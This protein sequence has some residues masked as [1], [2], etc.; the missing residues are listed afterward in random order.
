M[1]HSPSLICGGLFSNWNGIAGDESFYNLS[2]GGAPA[3][4]SSPGAAYEGNYM[5]SLSSDSRLGIQSFQPNG[6]SYCS[7]FFDNNKNVSHELQ[8]T[9]YQDF[10]ASKVQQVQ[11]DG[12]PIDLSKYNH[13]S[14]APL[15][16]TGNITRSDGFHSICIKDIGEIWIDSMLM[17]NN[18]THIENVLFHFFRSAGAEYIY[19]DYWFVAQY[20]INLIAER[21]TFELTN[22]TNVTTPA[23]AAPNVS[24]VQVVPPSLE[25]N[26]TASCLYNFVNSTGQTGGDTSNISMRVNGTEYNSSTAP[27]NVTLGPGN[28]NYNVSQNI[29]C[30]ILPIE[31]GGTADEIVGNESN[32]TGQI[33]TYSSETIRTFNATPF[34]FDPVNFSIWVN[35]AEDH[36]KTINSVIFQFNT[37]NITANIT[38]NTTNQ[39]FSTHTEIMPEIN[40]NSWALINFTWFFLVQVV[41]CEV[42][43]IS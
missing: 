3:I 10:G 38:T 23:V 35:I 5:L 26:N 30:V 17:A 2:A 24:N 40:N 36:T 9:V 8:F 33:L 32:S 15:I 29:S 11:T 7:V 39:F 20:D 41:N 34:E 16:A 43:N 4:N 22:A 42:V 27:L 19:F 37:T 31:N 1:Y 6:T 12:G 21:F 13:R 18:D 25:N 14:G 28:N